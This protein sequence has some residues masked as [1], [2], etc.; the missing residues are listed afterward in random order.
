MSNSVNGFR[1]RN[2]SGMLS[3]GRGPLGAWLLAGS[4]L[5]LAGPAVSQESAD[6]GQEAQ[7]EEVLVTGSIIRRTEQSSQMVTTL[8]KDD[9]M[10]RAATSAYEMLDT[11]SSIQPPQFTSNAA[12]VR[13]EGFLNLYSLRALGGERTLILLDGKR[14]PKE[15][16]TGKA[17]NLN[18]IP[19]SLIESVDILAD[20]ASSV[21][22]SDAI[23]G[24]IN[25]RT[26]RELQGIEYDLQASQPRLE[27][28]EVVF[29]SLSGGYGSVDDNGFNVFGGVSWRERTELRQTDRDFLSPPPRGTP[30][31][32]DSVIA[33]VTQQ[34]ASGRF[35]IGRPGQNPYPECDP[36]RL[37]ATGNGTCFNTALITDF[38]VLSNEM[39]YS[40]TGKLTA[41]VGDGHE[42]SLSAVKSWSEID[43]E[44]NPPRQSNVAASI[45]PD[46]PYYPGG[47]IVPAIPGQDPTLP[48]VPFHGSESWLD[49]R[50]H[51]VD[52]EMDRVLASL[53]GDIGRFSYDVWAM[54]SS[55]Y[56]GQRRLLYP[57]DARFAVYSGGDYMGRPAPLVNPFSE[58]QSQEL[59]DFVAE[60]RIFAPTRISESSLNMLGATVGGDIE[61]L[62][63]GGGASTFAIAA[64]YQEEDLS[65]RELD[66]VAVTGPTPQQ[67]QFGER[68]VFSVTGELLIPV[69]D[70]FE[71]DATLRVDQY[72]DVGSTT[73]PK[74]LLAYDVTD[75]VN[76]HASFNTGFRAPTLLDLY[77]GRN[78]GYSVPTAATA[79]PE[80]C[81][82]ST[83]PAGV[84]V[85]PDVD[86]HFDVCRGQYRTLRGGNLNLKPEESQ[87][88]A[89]G[90]SAS[91]GDPAV[92][93]GSLDF[94][95]D[96]WSYALTDTLG[97]IPPTV[98]FSDVGRFGHLILRCSDIED[99]SLYDE[100]LGCGNYT[101]GSP[102]RIGFVAEYQ[103][104]TGTTDTSGFD[105]R[106]QW[107]RDTAAGSFGIRYNGTYVTEYQYQEYDGGPVVS[108]L[109]MTIAGQ[110]VF[111]YKH[112]LTLLWQR[113]AWNVR[114]QQ[115]YKGSYTDCN[116]AG[117]SCGTVPGYDLY[118]LSAGYDTGRGV[119]I[120]VFAKNLLDQRP[121]DTWQGGGGLGGAD[122]RHFDFIGRQVGVT[123]RGSL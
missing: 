57:R 86:S 2:I 33:N 108:N 18:S 67:P 3:P 10:V 17:V 101:T 116:N 98:I 74:V 48:V 42:F 46:N 29:G 76:L 84:P 8:A 92:A 69:N 24:V 109:G 75:R 26:R 104:N 121:Y 78:Y 7:L 71:I 103:D 93:A 119:T 107:V 123:I 112:Y 37:W 23:A 62:N 100:T 68:D 5:L 9:I 73:N 80:R 34:D 45:Y 99:P 56:L 60:I 22:G 110:H 94:G 30:R 11:V 47:G 85:Y 49:G 14:L 111:E 95:A 35:I 117:T 4:G 32:L 12:S 81:D 38:A 27:G 59:M 115:L 118:T 15:P 63:L 41:A 82:T 120:N 65:F 40:A 72:G 55:S 13:N 90:F 96:Y 52:D 66:I 70:R 89:A 54:A 58:E 44:I 105:L 20:G 64:E 21:Y 43:Q 25:F 53:V 114:L 106:A 77:R 83:D 87:V 102:D 19:S 88:F 50:R 113:D 28:G 36:P 51:Q 97:A 1:S 16:W 6:D 31:R 91:V 79:D 122:I 39:Q 61:A